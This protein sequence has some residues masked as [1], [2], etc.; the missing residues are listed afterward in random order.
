MW[1]KGQQVGEYNGENGAEAWGFDVKPNDVV[2]MKLIGV[3]VHVVFVVGTKRQG[4][5]FGTKC[6]INSLSCDPLWFH[7][8]HGSDR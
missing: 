7:C 8:Q 5:L 4:K 6:V 3:Q 1:G 2:S